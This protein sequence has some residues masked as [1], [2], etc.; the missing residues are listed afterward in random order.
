LAKLD[1]VDGEYAALILAKAGLV[2]LGLGH[3]ISSDIRPPLLHHAVGQGAL[4]IEIRSSDSQAREM[5]RSLTHWQTHWKCFAERA[6]LRLLEG[7]CS[8]PVGVESTLEEDSFGPPLLKI[9]GCVTSLNGEIH[10]ERSLEEAVN[11]LYEAEKLGEKLARLLTENGAKQILEDV[12][13]EREKRTR[14]LDSDVQK[15]PS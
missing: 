13:E 8:V 2:R 9:T 7:G 1:A 12:T 5:C 11:S 6:M 14:G 3:R 4:A 10:I 15:A